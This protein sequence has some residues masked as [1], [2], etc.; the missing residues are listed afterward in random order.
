MSQPAGA[1]ATRRNSY[2]ARHWRG[3][4]S[5]A[6]SFWLN[7]FVIGFISRVLFSGLLT[8]SQ[9]LGS[10]N[11]VVPVFFALQ[12]LNILVVVWILVGIWRAAS[13]YAGR[14]LWAILAKIVV[15]IGVLGSAAIVAKN[16][17]VLGEIVR[18]LH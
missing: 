5:L 2:I 6:K 13:N 10:A 7:G 12:A 4:L 14:R 17:S 16:L 15:V 9:F 11:V 1:T 3:E 18:I 8:A